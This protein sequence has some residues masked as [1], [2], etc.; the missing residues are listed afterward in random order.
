MSITQKEPH[1]QKKLNVVY[2]RVQSWGNYFFLIFVNDL[3][4]ITKF[5]HPIMFPEDTNIFYS[6]SN[7]NELFDNVNKELANNTDW[8]FANKLSVNTNIFFF[9]HKQTDRNNVPRKLPDLKF[10]NIILKRVR[11]LKFIGLTKI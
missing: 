9:F 1:P 2:L 5:L 10:N 4:H 6:N 8:C 11:E 3:Q 7:I